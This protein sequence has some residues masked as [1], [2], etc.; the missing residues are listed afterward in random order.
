MTG[1]IEAVGDLATGSLAARAVEPA[2]GHAEAGHA[3]HGLCLNCGTTL[4]G[5]HCHNCGQAAHIHRSLGAI[6]HELA[7]G[8][9]HFE[10]KIFRTLPLLTWRPGEL[11]RRYI[12]GERARFVSPLALFLFS[13][14]LMFA[15]ISAL[16]AGLHMPEVN[17]ET[18]A[19][20][21]TEF[22]RQIAKAD[23][24]IFANRAARAEADR[25]GKPVAPIDAQAKELRDVRAALI[26]SRDRMTE[27]DDALSL[28]IRTGWKKL[29]KGIAKASANPNLTL[30]KIQS[31]AYKFSWALI[32]ISVPFLALLFL[33]R[34]GH[35]IYDHA[36]FVTYSLSFMTLM[37]ITLT[38]VGSVATRI[39]LDT[40]LIELAAMLIPPIHI[41]RQ[42]RGAYLLR[43]F[44]AIWR[45]MALTIFCLFAALIFVLLLLGMGLLG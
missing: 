14:F 23:A 18:K 20:T 9:F 42:L 28:N 4:L 25:T 24:E 26:T 30:Y 32:P 1:E 15:V 6:G 5:P 33:W 12:A 43:R 38:L 31:S 21:D 22:A 16:G 35:H 11:T 19:R 45:T 40:D 37:A 13:V 44:S 36:I 3:A 41:Y 8:V 29:D 39:G 17:A 34:R 10:G 7:H 27:G 2:H